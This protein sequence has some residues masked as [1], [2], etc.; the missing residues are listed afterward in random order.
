M[1]NATGVDLETRALKAVAA[2]GADGDLDLFY[3]VT[4]I[5]S[6]IRANGSDIY[7]DEGTE[8]GAESRCRALTAAGAGG[9]RA[10]D[11]FNVGVQY[12]FLTSQRHVAWLRVNE[13]S[14]SWT[15]S[16]I[17]LEVKVWA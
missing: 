3:D 7:S 5:E 12:C 1:P 9:E 13:Y 17:A 10:H 16:V 14:G 8:I 15:S 2:D 4:P 6:G 11:I